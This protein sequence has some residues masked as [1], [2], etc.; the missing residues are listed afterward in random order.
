MS[1]STEPFEY[2]F[3]GKARRCEY[4]VFGDRIVLE[5][6]GMKSIAYLDGMSPERLARVL[7]HELL[8][9]NS[10]LSAA[11]AQSQPAGKVP[12]QAKRAS[13]YEVVTTDDE[14]ASIPRSSQP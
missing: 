7:A 10:F 4:S 2:R 12:S 6:E 8:V 5:V 1:V 3:E 14:P 9:R 11:Q 13:D